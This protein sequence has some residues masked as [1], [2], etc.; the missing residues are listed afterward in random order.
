[1]TKRVRKKICIK[2]NY[3]EPKNLHILYYKSI[4][5]VAEKNAMQGA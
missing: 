3:S 5:K 1:L 4:V 2:M